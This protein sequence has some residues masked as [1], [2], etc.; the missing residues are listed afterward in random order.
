MTNIKIGD[1]VVQIGGWL[2]HPVVKSIVEIN[3][4]TIYSVRKVAFKDGREFETAL[5]PKQNPDNWRI[6]VPETVEQMQ[7]LAD[8][9]SEKGKTIWELYKSLPKIEL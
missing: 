3:P 5:E 8:E 9:M 1:Q 2:S 7:K 4:K 6:A